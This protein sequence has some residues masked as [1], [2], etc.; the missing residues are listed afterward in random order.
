MRVSRLL[1]C[2]QRIEIQPLQFIAFTSLINIRKRG[3]KA[4]VENKTKTAAR[5]MENG[6]DK[7]EGRRD[8]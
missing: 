5:K 3:R 2:R 8:K 7:Q 1:I 4:W 6:D